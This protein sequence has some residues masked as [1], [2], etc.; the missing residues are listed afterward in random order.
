MTTACLTP[1]VVVLRGLLEGAVV[2][3]LRVGLLV[4][5]LAMSCKETGWAVS[6]ALTTWFWRT[7]ESRA[8][9]REELPRPPSLGPL[10]PVQTTILPTGFVRRLSKLCLYTADYTQCLLCDTS[11]VLL[12]GHHPAISPGGIASGAP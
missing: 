2:G 7:T 3:L 8:E 1:L 11:R 12:E 6:G 5:V 9:P 4:G 10:R